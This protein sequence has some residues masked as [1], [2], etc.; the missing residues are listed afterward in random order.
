MITQRV[1]RVVVVDPSVQCALFAEG[2][3]RVSSERNDGYFTFGIFTQSSYS[4][5]KV[6]AKIDCLCKVILLF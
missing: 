6:Q 5:R 4:I 2:K 3:Q 1:V